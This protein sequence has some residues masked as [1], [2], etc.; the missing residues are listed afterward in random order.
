MRTLTMPKSVYDALRAH[1]EETFPEECCGVLVGRCES[2]GWRVSYSVRTRNAQAESARSR[3]RIEPGELM[4]IQQDAAGCGLEVAGFYHSHPGHP[5]QWSPAD[6]D[7]AHWVGCSYV[8]TEVAAAKAGRTNSFLL[9]G[10]REE[11]KRFEPEILSL[12][13]PE[14]Q[15]RQY[16]PVWGGPEL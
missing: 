3:Y 13:E 15:K 14:I 9:A 5:A 8:I 1:G 10:T 7:E 11:D 4:R 6:L 2:E 12:E 16:S